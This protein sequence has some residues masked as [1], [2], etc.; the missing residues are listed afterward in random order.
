MSE[1]FIPENDA[2]YSEWMH[3]N[4]INGFVLAWDKKTYN[5]LHQAWCSSISAEAPGGKKRITSVTRKACSTN[6]NELWTWALK[7]TQIIQSEVT[8]CKHCWDSTKSESDVITENFQKEV[9][10]ALNDNSDARHKRLDSA[11]KVPRRIEVVSVVFVRNPD[12]VAETLIRANGNCESCGN[13]APFMR[14]KDNSPYLEVHHRTLLAQGGE[15]TVEN[16]LALCPNCH[17]KAHY[18]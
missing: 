17:R 15:D 18:A 1:V 2:E 5:R 14:R 11:E 7:N 13:P 16:T 8:P 12:V 4:K 3:K 9:E 10:E 6:I